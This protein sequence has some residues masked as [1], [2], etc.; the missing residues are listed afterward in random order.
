MNTWQALRQIQATLEAATWADSPAER[1][2]GGV[3]I[4]AG[5][6]REQRPSVQFP[7][8]R[9][10]PLAL[11]VDEEEESLVVQRLEL[12][13]TQQVRGDYT[14]EVSLIGGTRASGQGGSGGRGLLELEEVVFSELSAMARAQGI[15]LRLDAASAA[16][17]SSDKDFGYLAFRVYEFE[18]WLTAGRVYPEASR[19]AASDAGSQVASLTWE[20]PADR[21]DRS[22]LVLR[23]ASGSTAPAT[24]TDGTDV[25]VASDAESLSDSPGGA[26]AYSYSLFVG[27]DEIEQGSPDRYSAADS[28]TVVL[29]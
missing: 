19:L 16:A 7:L 2:F 6:D 17:A 27:Y 11:Q 3:V 12:E 15:G 24:V 28:V 26:G 21:F 25:T 18:A 4:S 29:A 9:L 10:S 23:R 8:V 13:L 1:V 22:D 5:F 14:G 20:N